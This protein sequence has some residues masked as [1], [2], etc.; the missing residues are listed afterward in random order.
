M[1]EGSLD[2]PERHIIPWRDD[3]FYDELSLDK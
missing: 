1:K 3:S 2:A